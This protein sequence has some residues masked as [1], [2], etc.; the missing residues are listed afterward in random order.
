MSVSV[1]K[2]LKEL[3]GELSQ[4]KKMY[5]ELARENYALKELI[6]KSLRPSEKREAVRFLVARHQLSTTR[7]CAA[8]K[9]SRWGFRMCYDR[10]RLVGHGWNHKRVYRVYK[11]MKLNLRRRAKRRL[12][13]PV[14]QPMVVEA[15][16]NWS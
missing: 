10:L 13:T 12:P 14:Q 5:A 7:A 8:V 16:A 1:L 15:R 9:L 2:R 11:A 6:E 4:H 3:E